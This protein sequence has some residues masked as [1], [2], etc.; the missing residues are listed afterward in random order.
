MGGGGGG[1]DGDGAPFLRGR[2]PHGG[3]GFGG[4]VLVVWGFKKSR[5]MGTPH[6]PL[7]G[8]LFWYL[9]IKFLSGNF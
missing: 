2:A 7:P 5:K 8:R 1:S 9:K 4:L 3:I 6:P